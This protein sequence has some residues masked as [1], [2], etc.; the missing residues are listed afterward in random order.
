MDEGD[1][2]YIGTL[3]DA[4]SLT[5]LIAAAYHKSAWS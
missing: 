3:C 4:E 5:D 2:S 1:D